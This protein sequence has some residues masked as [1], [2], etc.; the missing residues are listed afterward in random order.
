MFI[1][2]IEET[3][4]LFLHELCMYLGLTNKPNNL[5][6][7]L[8]LFCNVNR[9]SD[10]KVNKNNEYL[11]TELNMLKTML[12]SSETLEKEVFPM[13]TCLAPTS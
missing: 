13:K 12:L 9:I 5:L 6:S 3:T 7:V 2:S 11:L 10:K 4:Y 1:F 8:E